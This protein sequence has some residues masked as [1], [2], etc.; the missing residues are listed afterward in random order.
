M[1]ELGVID[2]AIDAS[3]PKWMTP[4]GKEVYAH[5]LREKVIKSDLFNRPMPISK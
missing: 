1:E 5:L 2:N 3:D 4:L